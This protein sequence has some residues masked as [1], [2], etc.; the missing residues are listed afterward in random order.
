MDKL[1]K[2]NHEELVSLRKKI[3]ARLKEFRPIRIKK[4]WKRCGK[5]NCFCQDGPG[6][7]SWGNLHGPYLFAQYVD[8]KEQ[9]MKL[10]SL[11]RFYGRDD[12]DEVRDQ[13]LDFSDYF[14]VSPDQHGQMSQVEKD[15]YSWYVNLSASEFEK[16]HGIS[17][18]ED[19][20]NRHSRFYGTQAAHDAYT[21]A[22]SILNQKKEACNH[23]WV[24]EFGLASPV[25]QKILAGLLRQTYYL[26]PG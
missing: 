5:G 20:M 26:K 14:T 7:G 15:I 9:K 12:I 1:E 3:K 10:V 21:G 25:G 17:R 8:G 6:D 19:T 13:I 4:K 11:G 22:L 24:Y 18:S 23:T 16:Y 2:M